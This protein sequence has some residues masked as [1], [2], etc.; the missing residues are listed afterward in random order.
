LFLGYHVNEVLAI[1]G[2]YFASGDIKYNG[3]GIDKNAIPYSSNATSD[4]QGV[5]AA[6]VWSPLAGKAGD[7]SPFLK[8][9]LHYA[10][11][12]SNSTVERAG[13][14]FTSEDKRDGIGT[15]FGVGY[16]WKFSEFGFMRVS[17]SRYLKIAGESDNKVTLVSLGFGA[18]F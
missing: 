15:F 12:T 7:S 13:S 10:K 3:A 18:Q 17:A 4:Y 8:A 2:G 14:T 1:E 11:A 9:G 6:A 5:G 16:N